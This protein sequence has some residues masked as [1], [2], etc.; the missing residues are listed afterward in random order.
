MNCPGAFLFRNE[1]ID[2]AR[3]AHRRKIFPGGTRNVLVLNSER[4]I[5][6]GNGNFPG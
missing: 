6:A 4:P 2:V 5:D 1:T 3:F